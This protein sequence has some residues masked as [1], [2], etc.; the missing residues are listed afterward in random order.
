MIRVFLLS[1]ARAG[2]AQR[3]TSGWKFARRAAARFIAGETAVEA[4][5]IAQQLNSRSINVTLDHLGENTT[6]PEGAH[7]SVLEIVNLYS[8]IASSGV[9]ANISIKLSQIGLMLGED[10][11]KENLKLILEAARDHHN[12]LRIDMED[13][14]VTKATLEVFTWASEQNIAPVGIVIQAYLYRSREDIER[15]MKL[16]GRV[17]L[18]KGAYRE[19]AEVAFPK[20]ADVDHNFD[21]LAE[22][23]L[24]GAQEA[25][26]PTVSEDGRFPPIP[27]FATHDE[28]RVNKVIDW[29]RQYQFPQRAV[30]FQ[31]LYGI[32]RTLQ[33]SLVQEGYPVRVYVPY[34][35][36]WYP[37]FMR[38][39]AERPANLWFFISNYFRH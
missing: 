20:K 13:A 4:L 31:M 37:Y 38:R 30:E 15:L 2:W 35:T 16:Q 14:S 26:Y 19:L 23:L 28:K 29:M 17:R 11:C 18:C 22:L 21:T 39:L 9:R 8:A 27:A 34:G 36:H 3:V 7:Q 25:G 5:Q 10:I 33:E 6:T 24:H 1:L 12:F 32:N